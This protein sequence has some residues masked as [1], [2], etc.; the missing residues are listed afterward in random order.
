MPMSFAEAIP[1]DLFQSGQFR[2]RLLTRAIPESS[3][4]QVD[5]QREV[6]RAEKAALLATRLDDCVVHVT[7]SEAAA[8]EVL[9]LVQADLSH[10]GIDTEVDGSLHPIDAAGRLVQEDLVVMERQPRGWVLTSASVC[11][12]TRWDLPSK[13]DRTM[14]EIHE[15][16]PQYGEMIGT[17]VNRFFDRL[18]PGR[19]VWRPNWSLVADPGLRLDLPQRRNEMVFPNDPGNDLWL[20]AERQ[21]ARR[22]VDYPDAACFAVRVHRWPLVEILD[23]LLG[24]AFADELAAIPIDVAD[25]KN[26]ESIRQQLGRWIETSRGS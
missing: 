26:I 6:Y 7:G 4:L 9:R 17:V 23:D 12:P 24:S 13:L 2:W 11:F 22:L 19:L 8:Q 5:D 3:W 16:V 10:R 14:D 21:S 20:R 25:Y 1:V 15:P 18:Q